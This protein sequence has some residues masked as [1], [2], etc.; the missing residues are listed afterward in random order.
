MLV[1]LGNMCFIGSEVT[2]DT[3]VPLH[4]TVVTLLYLPFTI[5][6]FSGKGK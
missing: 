6:P 5:L 4:H 3:Q 2:N 1:K